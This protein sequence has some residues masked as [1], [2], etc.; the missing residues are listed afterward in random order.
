MKAT[1]YKYR[2]KINNDRSSYYVY[3]WAANKDRVVENAQRNSVGYIE[4]DP[5]MIDKK[6]FDLPEV[7]FI[8][9]AQKNAF[10]DVLSNHEITIEDVMLYDYCT[11]TTKRKI[12]IFHNDLCNMSVLL[13]FGFQSDIFGMNES[14]ISNRAT[15]G[16]AEICKDRLGIW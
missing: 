8:N 1:R 14:N 4:E 15:N 6:T 12:N 5:E 9:N 10:F 7:Q 2:C 3:T 16:K 13:S 11:T